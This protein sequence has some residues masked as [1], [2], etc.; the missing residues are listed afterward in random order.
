MTQIPGLDSLICKAE[1]SS[2]LSTMTQLWVNKVESIM[3][4]TARVSALESQ[5]HV[6]HLQHNIHCLQHHHLCFP[7]NFFSL[8]SLS[9]IFVHSWGDKAH[10]TGGSASWDILGRF[11]FLN[12]C[13]SVIKGRKIMVWSSN[14]SYMAFK[15]KPT[16]IAI[17]ALGKTMKHWPL[18]VLGYTVKK[19]SQICWMEFYIC[20]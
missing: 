20:S 13:P 5:A 12:W 1:K 9:F 10:K 8:T 2:Q 15:V 16:W 17:M 3:E 4:S 11:F 7:Y 14:V 19:I 18:W 6:K